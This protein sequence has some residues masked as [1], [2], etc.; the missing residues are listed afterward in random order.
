[1]LNKKIN[2]NIPSEGNN[3]NLFER[4]SAYISKVDKGWANKIKPAKKESID[5]VKKLSEIEKVSKD[6]PE[7]YKTYLDYMGD[8]DEGLMGAQYPGSS[9]IKDVISHYEGLH[10][11]RSEELNP[12]YLQFC[13][14]HLLCGELSFD[15]SNTDKQTI[16]MTNEGKYKGFFAENFEKLLFQNAFL[17]YEKFYHNKY[18]SFGGSK[19]ML[20]KTLECSKINDIFEIIE[21]ISI[22]NCCEK[23]WF[24]DQKHYICA[25][26]EL[27]IFV[28]KISQAITGFITGD[29][30]KY[31]N[32]LANIMIPKI[33]TRIKSI[34]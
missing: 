5:L 27:C 26:N 28:I 21:E 16:V 7:D 20:E 25:N 34:L 2:N 6:L 12:K 9:S 17:Q 29:N 3:S 24:S 22:D 23:I 8:N 10:E 30:E 32:E 33:G 13:I 14:T 11:D 19:S 15:L 1:M 31:I 4:L 18:I